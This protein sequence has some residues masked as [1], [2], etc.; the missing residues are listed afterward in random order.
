MACAT[1]EEAALAGFPPGE[2]RV[3]GVPARSPDQ[4][5]AVVVYEVLPGGY[6]EAS[7]CAHAADGWRETVSGSASPAPF[8]GWS[9]TSAD[10]LG[11]LYWFGEAPAHA[12]EAI[13]ENDD[14]EARFPVVDGVYVAARWN[15]PA[16][17]CRGAAPQRITQAV[18]VAGWR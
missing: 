2:V 7:V 16:A 12:A 1:P 13:V 4:L 15:V 10:E 6:H 11:V 5:G 8:Y 14:G 9:V 18:R 17:D 3:V